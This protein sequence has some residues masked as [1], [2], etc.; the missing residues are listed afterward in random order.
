VINA[1]VAEALISLTT[2]D[3]EV[4][5]L[6]AWADLAYEEIAEALDIPVGTV[7]SRLNRARHVLRDALSPRSDLTLSQE[8]S[9][10]TN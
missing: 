6:F 5:L 2:G 1:L 8:A 3:R 4:L 9:Q 10:W 7:R